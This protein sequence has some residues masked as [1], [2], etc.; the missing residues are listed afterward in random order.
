MVN[1]STFVAQPSREECGRRT[2][3]E[4][5]VG[6]GSTRDS[7]PTITN[8]TPFTTPDSRDQ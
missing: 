3:L 6:M 5:M 8:E 2:L 1:A 4:Y 7:R